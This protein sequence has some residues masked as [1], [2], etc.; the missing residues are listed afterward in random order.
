VAVNVTLFNATDTCADIAVISHLA[1]EY[2]TVTL[3]I[4]RL[5]FIYRNLLTYLLT[6]LTMTS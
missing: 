1:C 3:Y 5:T 2:A 6:Y 4:G